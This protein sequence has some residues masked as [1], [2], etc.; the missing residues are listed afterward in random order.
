MEELLNKLWS[1]SQKFATLLEQMP[2]SKLNEVFV[3]GWSVS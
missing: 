1:D 3:D 2:D